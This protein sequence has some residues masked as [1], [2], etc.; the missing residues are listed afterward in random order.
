MNKTLI[1]TPEPISSHSVGVPLMLF[2]LLFKTPTAA[3]HIVSPKAVTPSG[4][5]FIR[6]TFGAI[7]QTRRAIQDIYTQGSALLTQ[8]G[9]NQILITSDTGAGFIAGY[10][11]AKKFHLP[12]SLFIFDLWRGNFLK[13]YNALL[14]YLYERS[15]IAGATQLV[16][17][18]E[19]VA[20]YILERYKKTSVVVNNP[21]PE[22]ALLPLVAT[23][24]RPKNILLYPG[25]VYWAQADSLRLVAAAAEHLGLELHIYTPQT[26]AGLRKLGL[27]GGHI[28]LHA[29]LNSA[30]IIRLERS[31][32]IL[33]LPL[34]FRSYGRRVIETASPGKMSEFL[35]SGTPILC[36][37]PAYSFITR[38][39]TKTQAATVVTTASVATVEAALRGILD[40]ADQAAKKA[41]VARALAVSQYD[42]ETNAKRLCGALQLPYEA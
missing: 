5:R 10:R 34:S 41:Q 28:K 8:G 16:A 42:L 15:I 9:F 30:E 22:E 1:I 35:A 3:Y 2:R 24:S 19:G 39:L 25:S 7:S 18:G 27:L 20:K 29:P 38:L 37:A 33:I 17:A 6:S 36:V 40:A 21:L 32:S 13:P 31:A 14:A 26:E 11:L 23:A 4:S 12:Y